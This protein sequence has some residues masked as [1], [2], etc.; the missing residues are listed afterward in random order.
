MALH[1]VACDVHAVSVQLSQAV[2]LV[3]LHRRAGL[4]FRGVSKVMVVG[5]FIF[6]DASDCSSVSGLWVFLHPIRHQL[7]VVLERRFVS[8][9]RDGV[10]DDV[11]LHLLEAQLL[12][13][14]EHAIQFFV[15]VHHIVHVVPFVLQFA[16]LVGELLVEL[17][18]VGLQ[19]LALASVVEP[20]QI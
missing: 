2:D 9:L 14:F 3:L 12:V 8:M 6:D 15:V 4:S 7:L 13:L 19:F 10:G 17:G 16:P 1:W 18:L 5:V 11:V 20:L